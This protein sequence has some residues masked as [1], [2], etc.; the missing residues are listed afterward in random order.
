MVCARLNIFLQSHSGSLIN[1]LLPGEIGGSSWTLPSTAV[2][3]DFDQ[4]EYAF[5]HTND[6]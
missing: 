2:C 1:V 3:Y 4:K 5:I 6:Q